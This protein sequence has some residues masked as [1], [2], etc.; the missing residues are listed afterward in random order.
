MVAEECGHHS[1]V[2]TSGR[3]RCRCRC[4]GDCA[5]SGAGTSGGA[6]GDLSGEQSRHAWVTRGSKQ[7][8]PD[9]CW[10]LSRSSAAAWWERAWGH[11]R[12]RVVTPGR[13]VPAL[14]GHLVSTPPRAPGAAPP[15]QLVSPSPEQL[16]NSPWGIGCHPPPRA[17]GHPPRGTSSPPGALRATPGAL[18]HPSGTHGRT[19][20]A[21]CV[22]RP[23]ALGRARLAVPPITERDGG[24]GGAGPAEPMARW[25]RVRGGR[26]EPMVSGGRRL[27]GSREPMGS[28][29]RVRGGLTKPMGGG[30]RGR[31]GAAGMRLPAGVR[32]RV[33][34]VHCGAALPE[35]LRLYDG[36]ADRYEE[37]MGGPGP[38]SGP[39]PGWLRCSAS[40]TRRVSAGCGG[41]GVPGTAPGRRFARLRLPRAA[42]RGAAA[43]RGLWHRAGSAGG[44]GGVGPGR[45]GAG[46][47]VTVP[48]CVRLSLCPRSSIAA[49]SAACTAWTAARGCWSGRG[50]PGCT[51]SCGGVWW[52][53]SLC[54]RPQVTGRHRAGSGRGGAG[55]T[56]PVTP[57]VSPQ[58]T[59]TP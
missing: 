49:A 37:V 53:G 7:T 47:E 26:T 51:G 52:A 11:C 1:V 30:G 9:P 2:G 43:R 21:W 28:G 57:R 36:W 16:V 34:A 29:R 8:V 42:R 24:G 3:R 13:S 56:P 27:G 25:G 19:R 39:G 31:A 45:A 10:G 5:A 14:P 50:A 48:P 58:S 41:A 55:D 46:R 12:E 23:G 54:P 15:E 20:S 4:G 22:P 59:T 33:A 32:E 17:L 40:L 35:R 44:T 18:G 38:G 6:G